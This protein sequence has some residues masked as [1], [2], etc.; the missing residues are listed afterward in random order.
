MIQNQNANVRK[1]WKIFE[2]KTTKSFNFHFLLLPIAGSE[3]A[4]T[5]GF[6][7]E[8][9]RYEGNENMER[10]SRGEKPWYRF[11]TVNFWNQ[12]HVTGLKLGRLKIAATLNI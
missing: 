12:S 9:V 7:Y 3:Q 2:R 11:L 4:E 5:R 8:R 10:Y 6:M 1:A